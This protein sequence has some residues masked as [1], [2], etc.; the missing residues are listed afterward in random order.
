[1]KAIK[2]KKVLSLVLAFSILCSI[3]SIMP[4]SVS[5]AINDTFEKD[6]LTYTVTAES[7]L[8]NEV[9]VTGYNNA[10]KD[11]I[12][13]AIVTN[14]GTAYSVT[15]IGDNVFRSNTTI[16]SVEIHSSLKTIPSSAFRDATSLNK[17]TLYKG[18]EKIESNAFRNTSIEEI[19]L[20]SSMLSLATYSFGYCNNLKKVVI[21]SDIDI[22]NYSFSNSTNINEIYCYTD[23]ITFAAGAIYGLS[24]ETIMYGHEGST[25]ETYA[26]KVTTTGLYKKNAYKFVKLEDNTIP[27]DLEDSNEKETD[28]TESTEPDTSI[29]TWEK[30]TVGDETSVKITGLKDEYK[31][32]SDVE[33]PSKINDYPVVMIGESAFANID[34]IRKVTIPSSVISISDKAFY[35]CAYL[36]TVTFED[37]ENSKLQQIGEQAFARSTGAQDKLNTISL[38][39]SLTS[40]G[41]RAFYNR[42]N[43]LSVYIYSEGKSLYFGTP[44]K[45][46]EIFDLVS[47]TS[48]V[49]IYGYDNSSAKDYA[50]ANSHTFRYLDLDVKGL[51]E[52]LAEA[53]AKDKSLYTADSY[54]VLNKAI[55]DANIFIGKYQQTGD[56]S[57]SEV[58]DLL[59][60]LND[61]MD[62]LVLKATDATETTAT[63][64]TEPT[65]G[66]TEPSTG[67]TEPTSNPAPVYEEFILGDA[68]SNGI[69]NIKDVTYI[70][71]YLA[72]L[73]NEAVNPIPILAACEV[74]GDGE[75]TIKDVTQIQLWLA[76]F[77]VD[78]KI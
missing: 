41:Y 51:Q 49:K 47:G 71:L 23:N 48:N 44:G 63:E 17:V 76:K 78:F 28:P 32:T 9:S 14:N 13:P 11:V 22:P 29:F 31:N 60:A 75:I 3:F 55:R 39:A 74:D 1:M 53:Q 50:E 20:P 56:G 77:N 6:G 36:D 18:I 26:A 46:A 5:A 33:I 8:S 62:G 66:T 37:I 67:T 15:G 57:P 21:K 52:A 12:I 34:D 61:A 2:H 58:Q 59:K 35:H 72:R 38:P 42:A 65:T 69:V 45:G 43:L 19:E 10:T 70:Q 54:S 16:E 24:E 7:L 30:I 73:L 27:P 68:D 25:A 4:L 40:L 64:T